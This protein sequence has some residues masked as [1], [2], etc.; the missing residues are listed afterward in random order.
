MEESQA[1][2]NDVEGKCRVRGF[3]QV[4]LHT[5]VVKPILIVSSRMNGMK[6]WN[7]R[8]MD[9]RIEDRRTRKLAVAGNK[10]LQGS[11]ADGRNE[12]PKNKT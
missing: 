4:Q 6:R 11:L 7:E 1:Q 9:W 5:V 10:G 3:S 12:G 8:K 2:R